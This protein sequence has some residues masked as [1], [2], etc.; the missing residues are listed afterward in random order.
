MTTTTSPLTVPVGVT[1][2]GNELAI[3]LRQHHGVL[4]MGVAGSG[5]TELLRQMLGALKSQVGD[6]RLFHAEGIAAVHAEMDRRLQ[7]PSLVTGPVVLAFDPGHTT[8]TANAVRDIAVKGRA[9][10]VHL[11]VS[12][13]LVLGSNAA[14]LSQMSTRIVVGP[15]STQFAHAFSDREW[16]QIAET[17]TRER[18]SGVLVG[19]DGELNPFTALPLETR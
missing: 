10:D 4:I 14:V 11:L 16:E 7:D 8:G 18:Y 2:D 3:D 19:A 17:A 1:R 5:K 6:G 9:V 15:P 12:T 13:Q